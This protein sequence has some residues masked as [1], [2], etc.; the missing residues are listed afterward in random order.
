M[1]T[2]APAPVDDRGFGIVL[3]LLSALSMVTGVAVA[4]L[5]EWRAGFAMFLA[6]TLM[7]LLFLRWEMR[8]RTKRRR[9]VTVTQAPADL[10]VTETSP[11]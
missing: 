3:F 11:L 7:L 10:I 4:V 8:R 5:V 9:T 6:A 1:S 2:D